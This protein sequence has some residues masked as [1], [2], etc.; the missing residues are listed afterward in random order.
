M[1]RTAL[2]AH[3]FKMT[4]RTA[5]NILNGL[6]AKERE[7]VVFRCASVRFK[8]GTRE[9]FCLI[10]DGHIIRNAKEWSAFKT[11]FGF[12]RASLARLERISQ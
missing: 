9:R 6:S 11:P 1:A 12:T 7:M 4:R 2:T 10:F 3:D 8:S 5:Q